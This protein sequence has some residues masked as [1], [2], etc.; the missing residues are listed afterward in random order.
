MDE[1]HRAAAQSSMPQVEAVPLHNVGCRGYWFSHDGKCCGL[2]GRAK[3]GGCSSAAP[4]SGVG[5]LN[6][7]STGRG[8]GDGR[9]RRR[10]QV[11]GRGCNR[12]QSNAFK[13]I[14]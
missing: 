4:G 1:L 9:S 12:E 14:G 3:D 13:K 10:G 2:N 7:G 11:G 8:S 6:G 5:T